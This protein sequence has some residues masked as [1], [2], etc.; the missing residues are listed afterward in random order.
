MDSGRF[1]AAAPVRTC[2][3][4]SFARRVTRCGVKPRRTA[5]SE[6]S[7]PRADR[8]TPVDVWC[9]GRPV[10]QPQISQRR[11]RVNT[12]IPVDGEAVAGP[13]ESLANELRPL[14]FAKATF[15]SAQVAEPKDR[16]VPVSVSRPA[17]SHGQL[18]LHR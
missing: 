11:L 12:A 5:A 10:G 7:S 9:Q 13:A 15:P 18:P 8:A 4:G 14:Y 17:D 3:E 16:L 1:G 6:F 2:D